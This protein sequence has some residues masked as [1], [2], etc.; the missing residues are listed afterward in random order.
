M[1]RESIRE[2]V[3]NILLRLAPDF[4]FGTLASHASLRKELAA[5]S[6]DVLN[7]VAALHEELGIDVPEQ[8]YPHIAA[9]IAAREKNHRA[10]GPR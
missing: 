2:H 5:D 9:A 7:F 3:T 6:M 1:T 8:D 10:G 4:D